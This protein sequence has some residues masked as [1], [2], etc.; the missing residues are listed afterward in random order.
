MTVTV[1][2]PIEGTLLRAARQERRLK[3]ANYAQAFEEVRAIAHND[4]S[5]CHKHSETSACTSASNTVILLLL[6]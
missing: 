6:H 3:E 4:V 5:N 1:Q 2:N